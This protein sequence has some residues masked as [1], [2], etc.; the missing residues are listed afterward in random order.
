MSELPELALEPWEPK[1]PFIPG[2][3]S[4]ARCAWPRRHRR[5]TGGTPRSTSIREGG[6]RD[7]FAPRTSTSASPSTSSTT[8]SSAR[9]SGTWARSR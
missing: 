1:R 2:R 7:G 5:T 3:R 4:S 6:R 8:S 9:A